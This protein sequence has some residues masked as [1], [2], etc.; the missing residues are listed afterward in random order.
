MLPYSTR[1]DIGQRIRQFRIHRDLSQ[2]VLAEDIDISIN[3]L[4]EIENG[5]KGFSS[6]TLYKLCSQHEVSADYILFGKTTESAK[7]C[8]I[9]EIANKLDNGQLNIVIEYLQSLQNMRKI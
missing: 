9:I 2:A 7:T 8:E 4:S 3:F 1:L 6:E 5:K